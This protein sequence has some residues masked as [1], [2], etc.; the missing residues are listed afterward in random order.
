MKKRGMMLYF[1]FLPFIT[2][3]SA[4]SKID[5]FNPKALQAKEQF[6][7][8]KLSILL[9]LI[10]VFVVVV[11]FILFVYKYRKRPG[12]TPSE[13]QETSN[14]KLEFTWTITPLL[15]LTIL[16][17]PMVKTTFDEEN[18]SQ[19]KTDLK[20][21]V[22]ASQYS[23]KFDYGNQ[24]VE[25][26]QELHLP[27]G[28]KVLLELH[29]KDVIHSFW[30]P[31][32]GGKQDLIPGKTNTLALTPTEIGTYQG[33]CAE[34]CGPGHALMRFQVVVESQADYDR[35]VKKMKAKSDQSA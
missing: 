32:L 30:V 27:K 6:S 2:G 20:V 7:L 15:L 3:C 4:F 14:K 13:N 31:Q 22:T 21:V 11:L 29:A 25:T 28:K 35:W 1:L 24:G 19:S 26:T 5:V 12:Y 18:Q 23:W 17:I 10:V 8:I 34:L 33:K 16:A 9:M